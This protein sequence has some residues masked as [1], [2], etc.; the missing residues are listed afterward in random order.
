MNTLSDLR[1]TLDRH[2]D[3]VADPAAV[4]RTA[5]VHHSVAVVRRRRRA[6]GTGVLALVL[7]A[8]VGTVLWPRSD[9][10]PVP[11]APVVLGEQAPTTMKSLGYTY[12]TD[13]TAESGTLHTGV[14]VAKSD[15]PQ[16]YSW[17][18]DRATEVTVHV[19]GDQVWSSLAL[20]FRDFVVVPPNTWGRLSVSA[21]QG[22]VAVTR[23]TLA[24]AAPSGYTS[25]G[26]TYRDAVAGRPL[27]GATIAA[28]STTQSTVSVV[29]PAGRAE[30][31]PLC[32]GV[33]AGYAVLVTVNG[34]ATVSG[35]CSDQ[36]SF[37]PGAAGGYTTRLGRAGRAVSVRVLLTKGPKSTT[38]VTGDFP[39]LRLGVGVYGPVDQEHL[40]G[41]TVDSAVEL[42][43]HPWTLTETR[44]S[45]GEPRRLPGSAVDR[46]ASMVWGV[47]GNVEASFT[48][49]GTPTQVGESSTGP[50][51]LSGL[52]VPANAAVEAH[53]DHGKGPF[54]VAFYT[55]DD[56]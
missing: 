38:P 10:D 15:Q 37:D 31:S 50:A 22:R 2:A 8:A 45:R 34:R 42:G 44:S 11:A 51:G 41:T 14:V 17:T 16:L 24:D 4:A 40:V 9:Q 19:P 18:A 46:V 5:A 3:D 28:P 36:T 32:T 6:V 1:R 30:F 49:H 39:H 43:G 7:L 48:V 35:D 25:Q 20:H 47:K 56:Y 29:S 33:P 53:L 13:G 23:Y 26:V 12:R 27:L 52:W 55:R 21:S 54:A